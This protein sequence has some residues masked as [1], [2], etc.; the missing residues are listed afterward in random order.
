MSDKLYELIVD[1]EFSSLIRPLTS[2][3]VPETLPGNV[4]EGQVLQS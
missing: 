4:A 3:R 2:E 1:D